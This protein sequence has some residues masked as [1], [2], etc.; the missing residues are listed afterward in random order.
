MTLITPPRAKDPRIHTRSHTPTASTAPASVPFQRIKDACRTTGLSTYFL[1]KGCKNGSIPNV[2][3]GGT[4]YINV[5][6]L[7]EQLNAASRNRVGCSKNVPPVS[8]GGDPD[9]R[10]YQEV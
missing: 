7:L 1:R 2:R 3:S 9:G 4:Y 5:P 10:L 8:A 6:A